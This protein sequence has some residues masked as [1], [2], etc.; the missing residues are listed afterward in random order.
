MEELN[1]FS[2]LE[3]SKIRD[4]E[5]SITCELNGE[6]RQTSIRVE[7]EKPI[8]GI[9]Y[10]DDFIHVVRTHPQTSR[11]MVSIIKDFHYGNKID[12]PLVLLIEKTIPELQAT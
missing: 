3:I 2:V 6:T 7:A 4:R 5:Y 12:L 9:N 1:N 8:F 10:L 11:R